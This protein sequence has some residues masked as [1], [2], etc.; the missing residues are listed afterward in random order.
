M[1]LLLRLCRELRAPRPRRAPLGRRR[2][3]PLVAEA[4]RE[5][6]PLTAETCPHYLALAAEEIARRRAPSSSA[7]RPSASAP[8]ATRSG[9]RCVDGTLDLVVSDH[10][11]CPPLAEAARA[12]RLHGR[13]GRDR[14]APARAAR[15]L[16]RG[17]DGAASGSSGSRGWMAEAPGASR[18]PRGAGRAG[19][20]RATTPTSSPSIPTRRSRSRRAAIEHRHKLTPYL[21]PPLHGVVRQTWLR[22][23]RVFS[24]GGFEGAPRG[25][26]AL[27]LR[28][29]GL[30][31]TTSSFPTS[32]P[33]ASAGA[34]S[35]RTTSS[36]RPK[37]PRQA[38]AG[39]LHRRQVHRAAASGWTAGRRGG[40]GRRG[41]TG[42]CSRSACAAGSAR[43][44]RG[45]ELLRR[46]PAGAGLARGLRPAAASP[47]RARLER[48]ELDRGA[49]AVAARARLE[50]PL[51]GEER[52]SRSRTCASTS[53]P[54]AASRGCACAARWRSTSARLRGRVVDL[55]A[56][57]N[58]GVV[59]GGER[60]ALRLEGAP[61]PAGPR[62]EHG[63]GL[64]DEA[65]P[66]PGPRLGDRE[67]GRG[68]A[69]S[70]RS[71]STPR[72]S[73]A[74]IPTARRSRAVSRLPP[75]SPSSRTR[76]GRSSC[77]RPSSG[78]TRGTST[79]RSS[80]AR[81]GRSRTCGC[82]STRTAA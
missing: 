9:R 27:G 17:A 49:A 25:R 29:N 46:Q 34:R 66:R 45:H 65:A 63:R 69:R 53:S 73:R 42:A 57:E 16:D 2:A 50:Q 35:T 23:R 1:A 48:R 44:R 59:L 79:P 3:A 28:M 8:I 7:R 40:D 47:T 20:R 64:G 71:R 67:A 74:T 10:S 72:T 11:P 37:L 21:G 36:S 6:L 12:R 77:R 60:H 61:D 58:G 38:G 56:I 68:R 14:L 41:T 82:A 33:R 51:R 81:A 18:G 31:W 76:A 24:A 39:R 22:G 5:G 62:D 4:R 30:R 78:R 52:R 70:R 26:A 32:S 54:T 13:L 15:R 19:S 75:R 43:R 80:S 55:A